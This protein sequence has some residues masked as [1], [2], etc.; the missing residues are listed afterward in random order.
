M[1]SYHKETLSYLQLLT[2]YSTDV[3]YEK[4]RQ[5]PDFMTLLA[6][7]DKVMKFSRFEVCHN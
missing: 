1:I 4:P 7:S 2:L 3:I 6:E 5:Q